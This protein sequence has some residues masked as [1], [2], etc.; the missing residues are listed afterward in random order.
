MDR[1]HVHMGPLFAPNS[2]GE[3]R[4]VS[5]QSAPKVADYIQ[6]FAQKVCRDKFTK[7]WGRQNRFQA[8][9][10]AHM[11]ECKYTCWASFDLL[12]TDIPDQRHFVFDALHDA[13]HH[14]W[15]ILERNKEDEFHAPL[16]ENCLT[17]AK[18]EGHS[19]ALK[20]CERIKEM[21]VPHEF[22]V[23]HVDFYNAIRAYVRMEKGDEEDFQALDVSYH[24]LMTMDKTELQG[25]I[26]KYLGTSA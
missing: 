21:D 4:V 16:Y 13:N 17:T 18:E 23:H 8:A 26:H 7:Y 14:K 3:S 20:E 11:E 25:Y 19:Q 15:I 12:D 9:D 1:C 5:S 24:E 6:H 2:G 10:V 22:L